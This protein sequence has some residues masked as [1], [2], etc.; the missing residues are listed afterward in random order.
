M[1][2]SPIAL[3]SQTPAPVATATTAPGGPNDLANQNVF[4]QLLVA[5]L[6]YQNP[7]SPVDGTTFITQLAQFSELSNSTQMVSDLG[8]IQT[9]LGPAATAATSATTP[10]TPPPG[11]GATSGATGA[12]SGVTSATS[13]A[14]GATSGATGA[15]SGAT[16]ATAAVAGANTTNHP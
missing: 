16:G 2:T 6:K 12:T 7:D 11:A 15:A 3:S 14:T 4:L 10:G 9:E 8:T 1:S 5:Q 13:G